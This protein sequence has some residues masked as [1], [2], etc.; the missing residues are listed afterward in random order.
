MVIT[1]V[2]RSREAKQAQGV[3]YS[4]TDGTRT[5]LSPRTRLTH[6]SANE[7]WWW[8][9]SSVR[10]YSYADGKLEQALVASRIQTLVT[11]RPM[12]RVSMSMFESQ[13]KFCPLLASLHSP[14]S[15]HAHT[16]N[17]SM[18]RRRTQDD[19]MVWGRV[20]SGSGRGGQ[21]STPDWTIIDKDT[22]VSSSPC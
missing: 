3:G 18:D 8:F 7:P 10:C 5:S 14:P 4:H 21:T 11:L 19:A 9:E 20:E 13:A 2:T 17:R 15:T 6:G 1:H 22:R 16:P 12:S